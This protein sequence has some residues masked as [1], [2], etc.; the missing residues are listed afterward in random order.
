MVDG[1]EGFG[2]YYHFWVSSRGVSERIWGYV[3]SGMVMRDVDG[4]KRVGDGRKG[5]LGC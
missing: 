5:F 1:Q 3:G 2:V 4:H